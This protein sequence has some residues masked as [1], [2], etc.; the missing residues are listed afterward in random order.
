MPQYFFHLR[1]TAAT[2]RDEFGSEFSDIE[3]AYLDTCQAIS[4]IAADLSRACCNPEPY[5]FDITDEAGQV[6]MEVPFTEM[7]NRGQ[8]P[9]KPERPASQWKPLPEVERCQRLAGEIAEQTE[10]LRETIQQSHALVARSRAARG[11]SLDQVLG[12]PPKPAS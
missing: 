6:L 2:Q 9:L 7:L 1:S 8:T 5:V 11:W 12:C 4:G 10:T 3:A